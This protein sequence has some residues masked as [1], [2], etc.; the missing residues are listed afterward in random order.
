MLN[1]Y[2]FFARGVFNKYAWVKPLMNKKPK[3]VIHGFNKI[4]NE[5]KCKP[6]K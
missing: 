3:T 6:N 1:K 5:S 4:L 2:L